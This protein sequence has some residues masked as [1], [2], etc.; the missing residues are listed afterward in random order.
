MRNIL[1]LFFILAFCGIYLQAQQYNIV[2]DNDYNYN[3]D[4]SYGAYITNTK[5]NT[6]TTY[7]IYNYTYNDGS[8]DSYGIYSR[9]FSYGTGTPYAGYFTGTYNTNVPTGYGIYASASGATNNW[10]GYFAGRVGTSGRFIVDSN[11]DN[12]KVIIWNDGNP[13]SSTSTNCYSLGV[14]GG[15]FKFNVPISSD[16]FTFNH[17][18]VA[19]GS[20]TYIKRLQ[21]GAAG[22]VGSAA[23]G[24]NWISSGS[25]TYNIDVS[26]VGYITNG[27][28]TAS[29]RNFKKD[30]K[31]YSSALET[32][33]KLQAYTYQY[34]RSKAPE[35]NFDE[36]EHIGYLAQDLQKVVPQAV[37]EDGK[38]KG[39]LAVNYDMLI[40]VISEAVKELASERDATKAENSELKDK[41][42]ALESEMTELRAMVQK[43]NAAMQNCCL[44]DKT[45][46][47]SL[48]NSN[49]N[50]SSAARLEQNAPNPF[51]NKTIIQHYVPEEAGNAQLQITAL[52]GKVVKSINLNKGFSTTTISG[53]ELVAGT[54]FY[55]LIID[56]S[57]AATKEM[58]L[59]K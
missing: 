32:I 28:W 41:I 54:Y 45:E 15:N 47:G 52:D 12:N 29:D 59:T 14:D 55:T 21:A 44:S 20:L 30:I 17:G 42:S 34:D 33:S 1:K 9:N 10:A 23:V 36:R 2:V 13:I 58:I 57:N 50:Y 7:G 49:G 16:V 56:G 31:K 37:M 11:L 27:V 35:Y 4:I 26:G 8:G 19:G 48:I 18:D 24:V 38:G 25:V 5:N 51:Y 6:Y 40:P 53:S 39:F 22:T 3:S 43:M 46:T